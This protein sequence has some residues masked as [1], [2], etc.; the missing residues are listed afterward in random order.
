M[1]TVTAMS[2]GLA[3]SAALMTATLISCWWSGSRPVALAFARQAGSLRNAKIVS[4]NW[5]YRQPSSY[6][7]AT[8]AA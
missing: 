4:S 7:A 8:S 6:S 5:R 2:A 1:C 3:A